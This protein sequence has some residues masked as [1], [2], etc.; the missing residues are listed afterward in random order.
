MKHSHAKAKGQIRLT[1]TDTTD[2]TATANTYVAVDGIF[3]ISLSHWFSAN[4]SGVMTF[5][6]EKA[7][8]FL[9]NGVSDVSAD[10][11]C[12]ITYALFLNGSLVVPA[13]TPHDFASANKDENISITALLTLEP[14]D[15]IQIY[16]KS[17]TVSTIISVD[18]LQVTLWGE[19]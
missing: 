16:A 4:A 12:R 8:D 11:N 14:N 15:Y 10:K 2:L 6:G 9:F 1:A 3:E 13:Q 17:D 18:T 7:I 19:S 5:I